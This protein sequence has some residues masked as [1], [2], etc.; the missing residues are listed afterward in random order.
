MK[1]MLEIL[2]PTGAPYESRLPTKI[3]GQT[4][5]DGSAAS[6]TSNSASD[7]GAVGCDSTYDKGYDQAH[8]ERRRSVRWADEISQVFDVGQTYALEHHSDI[9]YQAG[10]YDAFKAICRVLAKEWRR[11]GYSF[12]LKD[13]FEEPRKETVQSYLNAFVQQDESLCRRGLERHL[14]RQHMEERASLR[15][16]ARHQVLSLQRKA[17]RQG[18][19]WH[20][21]EESIAKTY[22]NACREARIFARRIAIADAHCMTY[23]DDSGCADEIRDRLL[24]YKRQNAQRMER[25]NSNRSS[26]S[27]ASSCFSLE[28]GA[29]CDSRRIRGSDCDPLAEEFHQE[30]QHGGRK[31]IQASSDRCLGGPKYATL[32]SE[33]FYASIA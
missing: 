21:Y 20:E 30:L 2:T 27:S 19:T 14:S 29:S 18:R 23:G 13:S 33:E 24:G 12:L 9:W 10:D 11:D 31:Q 28:S 4:A 15:D 5:D 26:F 7:E 22:S 17:R 6:T 8:N 1:A 25:R 16:H 3:E 32:R